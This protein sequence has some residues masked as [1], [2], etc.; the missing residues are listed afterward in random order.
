LS[1]RFEADHLLREP[2]EY[3]RAAGF[4]VERLERSEWGIVERAIARKPGEGAAA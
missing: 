2:L 3:L 1:V 4:Q